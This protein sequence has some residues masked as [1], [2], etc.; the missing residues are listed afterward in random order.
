MLAIA[1][2]VVLVDTLRELH[3]ETLYKTPRTA[4]LAKLIGSNWS[5]AL[6]IAMK[7]RHT[8]PILLDSLMGSMHDAKNQQASD[9]SNRG[10]LAIKELVKI[11]PDL[12]LS[13]FTN[14]ELATSLKPS[15]LT[16]RD[17]YTEIN[18][19][20]IFSFNN[21]AQKSDYVKI[22]ECLDNVIAY[23]E[24]AE[25]KTL[26]LDNLF[27]T[28]NASNKNKPMTINSL[29]GNAMRTYLISI[30]EFVNNHTK[31]TS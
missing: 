27:K 1:I 11:D 21:I 10:F 29:V 17:T 14:K 23:I 20:Y 4:A 16:I 9:F 30:S 13:E 25:D 3:L 24:F 15:L 7:K 22:L 19:R 31:T 18:D 26:D 8:H 6:V 5:L 12:L 28:Y 2:T